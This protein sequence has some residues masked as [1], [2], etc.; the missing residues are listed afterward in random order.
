MPS[1]SQGRRRDFGHATRRGSVVRERRGFHDDTSSLDLE[2]LPT[3][4]P[5]PAAASLAKAL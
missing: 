2:T 5:A 1:F 3:R 4:R